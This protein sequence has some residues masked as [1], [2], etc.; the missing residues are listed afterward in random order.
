MK[1]A[2]DVCYVGEFAG[3]LSQKMLA[4][5]EAVVEAIRLCG[6]RE[7]DAGWD[8]LLDAAMATKWTLQVNPR[9]S[10][11]PATQ[12]TRK[13]PQERC[14]LRMMSRR[15]REEKGREKFALKGV[16]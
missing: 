2:A 11:T 5:G 10:R 4:R 16:E 15:G 6:E 9:K 12:K 8:S 14:C 7:D 3:D 1:G 13:N